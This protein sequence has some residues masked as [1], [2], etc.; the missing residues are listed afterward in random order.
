M[1]LHEGTSRLTENYNAVCAAAGQ[2]GLMS[3]YDTLFQQVC[4]SLFFSLLCF[5]DMRIACMTK[6]QLLT[7]ALVVT[8]VGCIY[9]TDTC[10]R[11]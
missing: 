10:L 2:L 3:L 6:L 7:L 9:I 11:G 5:A 4:H 1:E 8:S